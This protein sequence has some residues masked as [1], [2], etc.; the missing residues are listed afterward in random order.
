MRRGEEARAYAK[1]LY[2]A[3]TMSW[4]HQLNTVLQGLQSDAGLR[5]YLADPSHNFGDKAARL[6]ALLPPESDREIRNFLSLL[7]NRNE[8][9]LLEPIV[10]QFVLLT[11]GGVEPLVAEI[12]SAIPLSEAEKAALERRLKATHGENVEFRYTVKP[13]ILGGLVIQVGDRVIDASV[14]SKLSRLREQL[15]SAV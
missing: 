13:D 15:L 12:T 4:I 5:E 7:L 9:K 1:A 6:L 14:S 2:E 11:R 8:L 10:E 3:A